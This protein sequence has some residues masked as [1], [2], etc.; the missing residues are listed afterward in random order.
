MLLE[1]HGFEPPRALP[2]SAST[3]PGAGDVALD[4]ALAGHDPARPTVGVVFYR[5]HRLTGNTA[6]VDELCAALDG[7][8]AN[9]LPVWCYSLRPDARRRVPALE[10]LDGRV[11]ALI[12]TVLATGGSTAADAAARAT[13]TGAPGART[14]W[15]RSTCR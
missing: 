13:T 3:C 11:D 7:A 5:A 6:F 9:A 12:T 15:P 2:T 1:G 14:R 4:D 8:G 10:L